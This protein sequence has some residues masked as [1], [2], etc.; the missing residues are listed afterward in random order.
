MKDADELSRRF[1]KYQRLK[2][3]SNYYDVEFGDNSGLKATHKEHTFNSDTG[4]YEKEARDILFNEGNEIIMLSEKAPEGVK[5]PD[6]LLNKKVADIKT[7]LGNKGT[8]GKNSI[9]D[10]IKQGNSQGCEIVILQFPKESVHLF[11]KVDLE[12]DFKS[13]KKLLMSRNKEIKIKEVWVILDKEI[14]K[15]SY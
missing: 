8:I 15:F 4:K 2:D 10:K 5:T 13:S 6:G 12:E 3:D 14:K 1:E 9:I 11:E 7:V